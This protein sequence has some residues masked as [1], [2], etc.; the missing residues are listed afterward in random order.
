M[1]GRQMT[2]RSWRSRCGAVVLA[3]LSLGGCAIL[4]GGESRTRGDA[5]TL[6]ARDFINALSQI[7]GYEP[8]ATTVRLVRG[9]RDDAFLAAMDREL[10]EAG[11]AVQLVGD[12]GRAQ[13]PA[14]PSRE[15]HAGRRRRQPRHLRAGRRSGRDATRVQRARLGAGQPAEPAVRARCGRLAHPPRRFDLRRRGPDRAARGAARPAG[16]GRPAEAAARRLGPRCRGSRHGRSGARARRDAQ[17]RRRRR[18]G[19][20]ADRRAHGEARADARQRR[21]AA[22]ASSS[23]G[24]RRASSRRSPCSP[25]A[26]ATCSTS[27]ARTTRICS[28]ATPTSTS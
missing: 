24:R 21:A 19:A 12:E 15:R 26:R 7:D 25:A 13:P 14:V 17:A 1:R 28:R 22:G 8:P 4:G 16:T 6:V 2:I 11:Y 18:G 5:E 9:T 10:R 20:D 3:A 23:P 27:A